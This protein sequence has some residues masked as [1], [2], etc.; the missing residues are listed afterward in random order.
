VQHAA[1][2]RGGERGADLPRHL[3]RLLLREA[4]DALE[5]RREVL[6]VHVF[7]RQERTAVGLA[8]VVGAAD[9][10]VRDGAGEADFVVELREP[11]RIAGELIRQ[12]LER[13]RL[14][15]LQ[16][17]S[18]VD[19]AHPAAAERR[20]VRKRPANR[21]PGGK[22]PQPAG[23]VSS[24]PIDELSPASRVTSST[25]YCLCDWA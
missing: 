7:H 20:D 4:A 8:D 22:R 23:D 5:Q 25:R 10:A 24:A 2:V 17:V 15:E 12:Q 1:L 13:D 9:V 11:C 21:A 19:L 3:H 18:A 14:S 6:A 16:I